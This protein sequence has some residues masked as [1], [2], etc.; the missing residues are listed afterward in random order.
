MPSSA[1]TK[2]PLLYPM[3]QS[4]MDFNGQS[5]TGAGI[6]RSL[7]VVINP[8]NT[9]RT[10]ITDDAFSIILFGGTSQTLTIDDGATLSAGSEVLFMSTSGAVQVSVTG[11]QVLA[12]YAGASATMGT[13]AVGCLIRIDSSNWLLTG[14]VH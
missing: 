6:A 7:K 8:T 4:T 1:T 9:P 5:I 10:L 14:N 12:T 2:T 3:L 11:T 13:N